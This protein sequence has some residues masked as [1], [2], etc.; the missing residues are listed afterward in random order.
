MSIIRFILAVILY[1]VAAGLYHA[2][3]GVE[4]IGD[5]LVDWAYW[6]APDVDDSVD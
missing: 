6:L 1:L 5:Q 3:N 4:W 2:A